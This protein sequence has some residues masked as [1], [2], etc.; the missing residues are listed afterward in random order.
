MC[1]WMS[2]NTRTM[3]ARS[4]R[5]GLRAARR[6]S[7]R[8]RTAASSRAKT[9]CGRTVSQFGKSTVVPVRDRE[10]VRHERL[11]ALIHHRVAA[12]ARLERAARRRFQVD[13]RA[14]QIGH[15]ARRP[16]CR[17]RRRPAAARPARPRAAARRGRGCCPAARP[18]PAAAQSD[19]K[20]TKDTKASDGAATQP[21]APRGLC[22]LGVLVMS[23]HQNQNTS[24][25]ATRCATCGSTAAVAI[26]VLDGHLQQQ[27][28]L[29]RIAA[30]DLEPRHRRVPRQRRRS[31]R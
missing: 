7:G 30:A 27:V 5:T 23:L 31:C 8:D 22:V 6:R 13:D 24:C 16:A 2:Q 1:E 15:V 17:D 29:D 10:H 25:A 20:A 21:R 18:R 9:R 26:V 11:V 4:K 12:F 28:A 3:P 14:Q 19:T